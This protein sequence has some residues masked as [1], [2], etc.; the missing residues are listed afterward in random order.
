MPLHHQG[1]S[2]I[3]V[4]VWK[5]RQYY[6]FCWHMQHQAS[7]PVIKQLHDLHIPAAQKATLR[8]L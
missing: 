6:A 3:G 5:D 1:L 7:K 8:S 2:L 4:L